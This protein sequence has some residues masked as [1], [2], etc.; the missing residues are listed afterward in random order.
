MQ[1][2][3]IKL[4]TAE[5]INKVQRFTKLN[6]ENS[7]SSHVHVAGNSLNTESVLGNFNL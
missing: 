7:F 1:F 3:K 5:N 6:V 4:N 2:I